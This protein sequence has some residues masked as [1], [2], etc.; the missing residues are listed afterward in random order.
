MKTKIMLT[1]DWACAGTGF[2]EEMKHVMYRLAATGLY[3][4]YWVGFNYV[5]HDLDLPDTVFPDIPHTGATIKMLS[6]VGPPMLY[7]LKGFQRN[8]N[9]FTPDLVFSIGD[10]KNF[11]PFVKEKEKGMPF[12]Y[13]TYTTLDGVPIPPRFNDIFRN[14]N[15]KLSMTEWAMREYHKVGIQIGG[16]IH[17]GVNWQWF[18]TNE[19]QK[20]KTRRMFGIPDDTTLFISWDVNQFRKRQDALLS[21]W[22]AFKPESKNAKLFLYTDSDMAGSLGWNL[23]NLIK[24]YDIPRET[25]LLP[26][27]VYGRRK[28]W[29]QAEPVEFHRMI[30]S[31]GD[32]Y[33]STTSGEGFGKTLLESLSLGMPVIATDYSAI[34]EVCEK[35]S[36]LVPTYEGPAG[37]YRAQ[38][39]T[40][41]VDC[42]IV[43]QEKFVEAM[44]RLYDNP[45][46]A[47]EL[48]I[49]GRLWA[50][51]FDYDTMII[52]GWLNI[53]GRINP[54][55]ILAEEVL[56][57]M[58]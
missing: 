3:E 8:F 14:I 44:T 25:I 4:I 23:E 46:E 41:M 39:Q 49:Q 54:D 38:D 13:I 6:G 57:G 37:R 24:Q 27:D 52:P 35:G 45:D 55:L 11:E 26:E 29:E 48:G 47:K 42:G 19:F 17:H 51:N 5:G 21:C 36:V 28:F 33:V 56:K 50:K 10:P 16:H 12:P 32:I 34:P 7:G 15:V 18:S 2:S 1:T 31:M 58:K 22:K 43:N 20:T 53:L 40:R 30:A 9:R